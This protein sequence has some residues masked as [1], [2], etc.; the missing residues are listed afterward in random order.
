[1]HVL[2][3]RAELH[4]PASNSLKVKRS[5]VTPLIRHLDQMAGV[6]AAEVDFHDKW[7]RT[8]VGVTVVGN[9]VGHVQA[10]GDTVERYVWSRPDVDVIELETVWWDWNGA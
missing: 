7:Q 1:M 9:Q 6:A 5:I 10:V 8:A 2:L 3:V 4:L